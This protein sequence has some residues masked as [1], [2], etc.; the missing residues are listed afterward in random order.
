[1][2]CK[3]DV[4]TRKEVHAKRRSNQKPTFPLMLYRIL[5][6]SEKEQTQKIVAW[7]DDGSS[8]Q[9][10]DAPAFNDT[11]LPK[12]SKKKS[13]TKFR[14]FQR[15][16]NIYGFKMAKKS[17]VYRHSL[18]RR[19]QMHSIS[20]IR[21]RTNGPKKRIKDQNETD[22]KTEKTIYPNAVDSFLVNSD[23]EGIDLSSN[24]STSTNKAVSIPVVSYDALE[25]LESIEK[26]NDVNESDKNC[27]RDTTD[28]TSVGGGL[29]ST[30]NDLLP[31]LMDQGNCHS[32]YDSSENIIS[33]EQN[34]SF[35][36][37]SQKDFCTPFGIEANFQNAGECRSICTM[38]RRGIDFDLFDKKCLEGIQ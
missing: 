22:D 34:H 12:Y 37:M 14:S 19:G 3:N 15:Q 35:D 17:G 1:M 5:E 29:N 16:L 32:Q 30:V 31:H 20:R 36:A 25:R 9:I 2:D 26:G 27:T 24:L 4:E 7:E 21:P 10:F 23:D 28:S 18:F 33:P 13:K 6:D 8:F 38:T 11:I